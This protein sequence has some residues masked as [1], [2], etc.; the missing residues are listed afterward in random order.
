MLT[1]FGRII[2]QSGIAYSCR[3]P[4]AAPP[5]TA[6]LRVP[7]RQSPPR[8]SKTE[9]NAKRKNAKPEVRRQ[10]GLAERNQD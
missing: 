6:I 8:K 3:R 10:V 2:W 5:G 4:A 1:R 7:F 9:Q